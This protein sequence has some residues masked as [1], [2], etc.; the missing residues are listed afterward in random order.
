MGVVHRFVSVVVEHRH[1]V[2]QCLHMGR[3]GLKVICVSQWN[4]ALIC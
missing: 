1:I 2:A 3:E 4:G